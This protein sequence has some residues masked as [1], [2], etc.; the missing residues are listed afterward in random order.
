MEGQRAAEAVVIFMRVTVQEA[1][2]EVKP[3]THVEFRRRGHVFRR[4]CHSAGAASLPRTKTFPV[5]SSGFWPFSIEANNWAR[6]RQA[7]HVNRMY[8]FDMTLIEWASFLF[9]RE[10]PHMIAARPLG[11]ANAHL[12]VSGCLMLSAIRNE[13]VC[14]IGPKEASRSAQYC[15]WFLGLRRFVDKPEEV[16]RVS[17]CNLRFTSN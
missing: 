16:G 15:F 7:E 14:Y 8:H 12:P 1:N 6:E 4:L 9:R 5:R 11:E 10:V 2:Y 13:S 3:A 17:F